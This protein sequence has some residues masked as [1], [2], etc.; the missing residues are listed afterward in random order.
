[1]NGLSAGTFGRAMS[2]HAVPICVS[3]M[4]SS[5]PGLPPR[6]LGWR[7]ADCSQLVTKPPLPPQTMPVF[8]D[9]I[10]V[11]VGDRRDGHFEMSM[12]WALSTFV[13]SIWI[14]VV[15]SLIYLLCPCLYCQMSALFLFIMFGF[16]WQSHVNLLLR[17]TQHFLFWLLQN[18]SFYNK[19]VGET[20]IWRNYQKWY[21][22][23]CLQ[24]FGNTRKGKSTISTS[25]I[26]QHSKITGIFQH[27]SLNY[28]KSLPHCNIWTIQK[29]DTIFFKMSKSNKH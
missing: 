14:Y 10:H 23:L 6:G 11:C 28:D 24:L 7:L 8:R 13:A 25:T 4:S 12:Y 5:A 17:N 1:M 27:I 22:E 16:S 21:V 18:K 29:S 15:W 3:I 26:H 9:S 2:S 20:L 19:K